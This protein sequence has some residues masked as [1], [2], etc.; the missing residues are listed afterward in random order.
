MYHLH[1]YMLV[2]GSKNSVS[3]SVHLILHLFQ[4]DMV[5]DFTPNLP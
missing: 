3:N 2:L 5:F 4:A 1:P